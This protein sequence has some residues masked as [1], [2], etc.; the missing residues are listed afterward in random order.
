MLS[1]LPF[2]ML[3]LVL[4]DVQHVVSMAHSRIPRLTND[5]LSVFADFDV[6]F[7]R[8]SLLCKR[9]DS[10]PVFFL[11]KR[12]NRREM[13]L[14]RNYRTSNR[15]DVV[16]CSDEK[17]LH[18]FQDPFLLLPLA[19]KEKDAFVV[20][21]DADHDVFKRLPNKTHTQKKKKKKKKNR[22][23]NKPQRSISFRVYEKTT[24]VS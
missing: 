12:P 3:A 21:C 24:Y 16:P 1:V 17:R 19:F 18:I 11:A 10:L 23:K 4:S 2:N 8:N 14:L 5:K 6:H 13:T 22:I 20:L 15:A 9:I 7:K